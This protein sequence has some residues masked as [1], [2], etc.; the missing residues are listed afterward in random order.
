MNEN[1]VNGI[2]KKNYWEITDPD[3]NGWLRHLYDYRWD[4]FENISEAMALHCSGRAYVLTYK[5]FDAYLY[6]KGSPFDNDDKSIWNKKEFPALRRSGLVSMIIAIDTADTSKRY[7]LN[8]QT[9]AGNTGNMYRGPLKKDVYSFKDLAKRDCKGSENLLYQ[10]PG[11]DW[12][13]KGGPE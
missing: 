10:T 3:P 2:T 6:G 13:G 1:N 8:M 5:P 9:G 12:F 7:I 4:Y 11:E